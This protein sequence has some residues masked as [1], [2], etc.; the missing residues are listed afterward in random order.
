MEANLCV[1]HRRRRHFAEDRDRH[2]FSGR[3]HERLSN[4]RSRVGDW[5]A[6]RGVFVA[7]TRPVSTVE[8]HR[9]PNLRIA[10]VGLRGID[11]VDRQ[12]GIVADA[13]IGS[14]ECRS[15]HR[16]GSAR[17][18]GG[19]FSRSGRGGAHFRRLTYHPSR[20]GWPTR[21][22]THNHDD[23]EDGD[24]NHHDATKLFQMIPLAVMTV[25]MRGGV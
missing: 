19:G 11:E 5:L 12:A 16:F 22:A 3:D 9:R 23:N 7:L 25:C 10:H 8:T 13:L 2:G 15:E 18:S 24:K 4:D 6:G 17:R 14:H 21:H 1:L 20:F